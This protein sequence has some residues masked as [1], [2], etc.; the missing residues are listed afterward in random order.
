MILLIIKNS[1]DAGLGHSRSRNLS[2]DLIIKLMI[3]SYTNI[4]NR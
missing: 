2:V 4:I 3:N 1:I